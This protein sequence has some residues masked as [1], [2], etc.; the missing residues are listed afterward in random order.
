MHIL[1]QSL[2]GVLGVISLLGIVSPVAALPIIRDQC[3][4]TSGDGQ[5]HSCPGAN[6]LLIRPKYSDG[7]CGDWMCCPPNGDGTYNCASPTNPTNS[8]ISGALKN[9]LGPRATVL[10]PGRNPVTKNPSIF[11]QQNAPI[12]RRG[13]EGDSSTPSPTVPTEAGK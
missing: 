10:E 5:G 1:Q 3:N 8:A 7:T 4:Q 9:L 13:V 11:Q 2:W 12:M 6:D